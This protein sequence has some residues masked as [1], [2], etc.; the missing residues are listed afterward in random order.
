[1]NISI[2]CFWF[3]FFFFLDTLGPITQHAVFNFTAKSPS[4][5]RLEYKQ[6]VFP[7]AIKRVI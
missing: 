7:M 4:V 2:E 3:F 1:M 5:H 6:F